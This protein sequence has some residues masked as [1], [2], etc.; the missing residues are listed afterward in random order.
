MAVN[1]SNLEGYTV[2]SSVSL[3][4]SGATLAAKD[5]NVSRYTSTGTLMAQE[6]WA[7]LV[8]APAVNVLSRITAAAITHS[9]TTSNTSF[10]PA[11]LPTGGFI[12]SVVSGTQNGATL[13]YNSGTTVYVF[14]SA[15]S[16]A[17]K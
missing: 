1:T 14:Y 13:A 7:S 16:A 9:G 15:V 12:F 2:F 3:N 6:V 10:I 5:L 4:G 8:S 17:Q 11:N